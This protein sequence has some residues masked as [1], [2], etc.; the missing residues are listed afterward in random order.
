M[1]SA[2]RTPVQER[3]KKAFWDMDLSALT[4]GVFKNPVGVNQFK[5]W[6]HF[7]IEN[8]PRLLD[9]PGEYF[10]ARRG[11]FAG[12]LYLWPA[13]DVDPNTVKYHVAQNRI[14]ISINH[15]SNIVISGLEFRYN[16]PYEAKSADYYRHNQRP[17]PCI[18]VVGN[19]SNITV[20]N[21]P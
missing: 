3:G 9:S 8:L 4:T 17:A 10:F 11:P 1:G 15:Q 6:M 19:C 7:M 12:R 14:F 18:L 13:G 2:V 20:K 21:C 5:N 16:D